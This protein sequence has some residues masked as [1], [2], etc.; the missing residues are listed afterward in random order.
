[1]AEKKKIIKNR[2]DDNWEKLINELDFIHDRIDLIERH[3]IVLRQVSNYMVTTFA[4]ML[5][6]L[7]EKKVFSQSEMD[8]MIKDLEKE[9]KKEV[10]KEVEKAKNEDK[11]TIY[12]AIMKSDIGGNA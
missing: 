3:V 1:M 7:I 2:N 11:Q 12:D 9:V 4:S 10:E 5:K 8:E 6:I